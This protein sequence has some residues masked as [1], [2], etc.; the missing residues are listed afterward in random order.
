MNSGGDVNVCSVSRH[1][2][3]TGN[4]QRSLNERVPPLSG[5][6]KWHLAPHTDFIRGSP[7]EQAKAEA[8][9]EA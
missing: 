6:A 9:L 2:W 5:M 8:E 3:D 1:A 7:G 4:A